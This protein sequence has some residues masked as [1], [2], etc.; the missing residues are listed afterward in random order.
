[1]LSTFVTAVLSLAAVTD[2]SP[3]AYDVSSTAFAFSTTR[4]HHPQPRL[5]M[6][7]KLHMARQPSSKPKATVAEIEAESEELR[8]EI[9]EL[10]KEALRRLEDLNEMLASSSSSSIERTITSQSSDAASTE[11]GLLP[12]PAPI[13][14]TETKSKSSL[15]KKGGIASLLDET[16]WKISLSI[17]REPG[18]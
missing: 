8:K 17:G 10:R 3:Y 9:E 11:E 18:M 12:A 6:P 15:K 13:V 4:K 2:G 7:T 5:T 1:M 14:F 16:R